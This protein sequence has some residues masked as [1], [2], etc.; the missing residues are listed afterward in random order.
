M[1][2]LFSKNDITLGDM[3]ACAQRELNLRRKAY[4][5]FIEKGSIER[6]TAVREI[7][8]MAAILALLV[9]L[10]EDRLGDDAVQ[11]RSGT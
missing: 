11:S 9:R 1:P 6:T 3:I 5:R 8:L 7:A 2:D 10:E 4:P